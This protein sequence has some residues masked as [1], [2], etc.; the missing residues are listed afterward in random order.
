MITGLRSTLAAA[1]QRSSTTANYA[2]SGS[3]PSVGAAYMNSHAAHSPKPLPG[4]GP[5]APGPPGQGPGGPHGMPPPMPAYGSFAP[6]PGPGPPPQGPMPGSTPQGPPQLPP[7]P[8]PGH[9]PAGHAPG[10]PVPG[11][12]Q[13]PPGAGGCPSGP[14]P[15]AQLDKDRELDRLRRE[16]KKADENINFFRTQVIALQQQVSS[17][18]M[19]V[20][21]ASA[22]AA[23]PEEIAR[24]RAELAEERAERQVMQDSHVQ[25]MAA[26]RSDSEAGALAMSAALQERERELAA[27]QGRVGELE[28]E[29][30]STRQELSAMHVEREQLRTAAAAAAA[31]APQPPAARCW[32]SGA[33]H[34]G[35]PSRTPSGAWERYGT[36]PPHL[37]QQRGMSNA[38]TA[39]FPSPVHF[40]GDPLDP[41][42]NPGGPRRAVIVGCDYPGKTGS[43]RAGVSDAL[44]W[45]KFFTKR[46]G[47]L[48]QDL[49][50]L[51][52]DPAQYQQKQRP[53]RAVSTREN[54]L[55]AL[56][57]LTMRSAPGDQLFFVFCGHGA[58]IV[59][60]EYA[61]RTLCEN[62]C[63]PTDV[64]EG[65]EQPRVLSDTDMHKALLSVPGGVQVTLLYDSCHAGR[66]LDRSGM[67]FLTDYVDR[68][69]VDYEK[70]KAH[71]VRPRFL[72]LPHWQAKA[73]PPDAMR[74][75]VL[76]CQA[77]H[78]AACANAQFCVEIPIDDRPRGVFSYLFINALLKAGVQATSG[79]LLHEAR[80]LNSQL[81]GRW[82]LQQDAQLTCCSST[83]ESQ[84]FLR[85]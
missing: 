71:P 31:A 70:F 55:R 38:T 67:D 64:F 15:A 2:S 35:T 51:C 66:P 28:R 84:P 26:H 76:R 56:Q 78:W 19:P 59:A 5:L 77:V 8:P 50:F 54:V 13:P 53:D 6:P 42:E 4:G 43:L 9:G 24:L 57:W 69:H 68:G 52:D 73:V 3:D 40:R 32:S 33:P 36:P 37:Q 74:E 16:L 18:G 72:Q 27:S 25:A 44:Q 10:A 11:M 47:L 14:D 29:L 46:C 81:R 48:E 45:V 34:P 21:G 63:V 58:Q 7:G 39:S 12:Q 75:S 17:M 85:S 22:A 83:S 62:A 60:E 49:R 80:E 41:N 30:A 23:M 20:M 82:R 1:V 61:G 79:Q 65:G